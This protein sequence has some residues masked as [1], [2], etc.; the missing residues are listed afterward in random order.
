MTPP[1]AQ[2]EGQRAGPCAPAALSCP[3]ESGPLESGPP[4]SRP[5]QSC[6]PGSRPTGPMP[7]TLRRRA[8]FLRAAAAARRSAPGFMLQARRRAPDEGAGRAL[9]V[10]FTCSRKVGNAV[11]RNRARRRLRAVARLVLPE[12]GRAGWDY[13]LVG[14]PGA[15]I[16]RDFAALVD[17]LRRALARVHEGAPG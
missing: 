7:A 8:D 13:V 17:D 2:G 14:R 3:L 5:R 11:L 9:R 10:G 1:G 15:T 16:E 4:E 12:D 6:P